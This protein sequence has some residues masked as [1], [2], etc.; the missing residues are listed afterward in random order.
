MATILDTLI[1]RFGFETDKSGLDKAQK[2][3]TDFKATVFKVAAGI[4]SILGGGFLLNQ[5]AETAD[6]TIKW[7]DANGLAVESLGELEF[8]TQ[9]QGGTVEGLRASLSNLNK[10]IGEVERGTG[11]AKLAF[12]DYGLSVHKSNGD[13]KTADELLVDLNKKFVTLSKAQQ[14][15]LAMKMGIDKGTILLLQTAPEAIADLR[16][17]AAR[18]GV[19]SRQDAARAAEFV[20]GMTNIAQ[21]INAI[22]FEVAG[23]FFEPL[24]K[25]FKMIAN[26]ISFFREHKE[27]LLSIIGILGAVGVAYTTM[28]IR[29][30]AAWILALGP[31][32]LIPIAI[33]VISVAIAILGE[34]LFAFFSG[35]ESAIGNF[36]KKFPKIE[37]AFRSFGDFLG[38]LLFE[39]VEGFK[40]WWHWLTIIGDGIVEF[41]KNPLDSV[42]EGFDKLISFGGKIPGLDKISGFFGIGQPVPVGAVSPSNQVLN[43]S[44]K[45][46]SRTTGVSVGNINIDARGGDSKEIAENVDSA[47]KEQFKNTVED[48]DSSI[49][50]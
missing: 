8:A 46:V 47:L 39:T 23:F 42:L 37:T 3:L 45:S 2:G 32:T 21:A 12:E 14:F 36:L 18:L 5:I 43:Q 26:G 24:A 41:I 13:T 33:G 40:L 44:N 9:R 11:R 35:S 34:E 29:A 31:F 38:L 1:T 25:F 22:K 49:D 7:A 20:D 6:E 30:A 10:S 15:D 19:L 4:G 50:R 27:I 16:L 48:F 17:E 28:G